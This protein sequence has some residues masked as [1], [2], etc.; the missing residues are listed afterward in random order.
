MR[1]AGQTWL[2][3]TKWKLCRT[4]NSKDLMYSMMTTVNSIV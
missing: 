3:G 1:Q 2:K 4:A